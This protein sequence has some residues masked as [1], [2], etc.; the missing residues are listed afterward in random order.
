MPHASPLT[1]QL[2]IL[3]PQLV[4]LN[5]HIPETLI[6]KLRAYIHLNPDDLNPKS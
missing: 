1:P 4:T 3:I 2:S 6:R 5:P